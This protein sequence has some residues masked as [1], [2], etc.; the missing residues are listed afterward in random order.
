[1]QKRVVLKISGRVQGVFYRINT[2]E[3]ATKLNIG[4]YIKN[5]LDGTVN[6]IA[7]GEKNNLK[8]LVK[9][10]YQGSPSAKVENVDEKW[11]KYTGGFN[12]FEIKY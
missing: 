5:K 7:E 3:K 2:K 12:N 8:E 4:G 11:E 1:M 6:I 10:C 9:W